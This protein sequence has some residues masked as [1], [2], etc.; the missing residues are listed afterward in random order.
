MYITHVTSRQYE[1]VNLGESG[2]PVSIKCDLWVDLVTL[3][4]HEFVAL[5]LYFL[6]KSL[7]TYCT[8]DFETLFDNGTTIILLI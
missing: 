4:I 6:I 8:F 1:E 5:V 2:T 7:T 3:I